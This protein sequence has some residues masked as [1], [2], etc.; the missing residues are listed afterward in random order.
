MN[1]PS[2][3]S[4]AVDVTNP[5]YGDDRSSCV[6]KICE[7]NVD[8]TTLK[9]AATRDSRR[10]IGEKEDSISLAKCRYQYEEEHGRIWETEVGIS[11]PNPHCE[12]NAVRSRR[13]SCP[14]SKSKPDHRKHGSKYISSP[15]IARTGTQTGMH[16]SM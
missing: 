14:S 13:K 15:G 4:N 12:R 10:E 7:T 16:R 9:S 8:R 11:K 1:H 6:T 5:V 2:N 3:P